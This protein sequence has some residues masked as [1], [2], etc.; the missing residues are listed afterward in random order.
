VRVAIADVVERVLRDRDAPASHVSLSR[1]WR[2]VS[3]IVTGERGTAAIDGRTLGA[4]R[5]LQGTS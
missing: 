2:D 3:T 1:S 4:S 5:F